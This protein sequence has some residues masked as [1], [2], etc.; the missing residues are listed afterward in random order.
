MIS[1]N[2]RYQIIAVSAAIS[3]LPSTLG[4][5]DTLDWI[6]V[7]ILATIIL[8]LCT[9]TAQ[10]NDTTVT[11]FFNILSPAKGSW[12]N[13]LSVIQSFRAF[14]IAKVVSWEEWLE[15]LKEASSS[16]SDDPVILSGIKLLPFFESL[17][18]KSLTMTTANAEAHSET[19][20]KLPP[21][22]REWIG[23]WMRQWG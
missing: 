5:S 2:R 19:L 16:H 15:T 17:G 14:S 3:K 4:A 7:D 1:S 18:K 21:V 9:L 12:N 6:P 13:L 22:S 10:S 20:A 11:T 23:I 8:E